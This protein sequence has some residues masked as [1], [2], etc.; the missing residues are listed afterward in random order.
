MQVYVG[1]IQ[2]E[3]AALGSALARE[4]GDLSKV[5]CKNADEMTRSEGLRLW[6]E[7]S[8]E[9]A[10]KKETDMVVAVDLY[11]AKV[12]RDAGEHADAYRAKLRREMEEHVESFK[13]HLMRDTEEHER[14]CADSLRKVVFDALWRAQE[15]VN[16]LINF[17]D[18]RQSI[19]ND[20]ALGSG[21]GNGEY[22][23]GR[24]ALVRLIPPTGQHSKH[25]LQCE[26]RETESPTMAQTLEQRV[27]LCDTNFMRVQCVTAQ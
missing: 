9:G 2:K 7:S 26:T 15:A 19:A 21:G 12:L 5:L 14:V 25:E 6:L 10:L 16:A 3:A 13:A 27:T 22:R 20:V 18:A 4:T 23:A 1:G 11:K 17:Q 24:G 8:L